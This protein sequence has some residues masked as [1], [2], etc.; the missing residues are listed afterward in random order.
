MALARTLSACLAVV[1][2]SV[3]LAATVPATRPPAK[4]AAGDAKAPSLAQAQAA[5]KVPLDWMA[6]TQVSWDV[7][8][9][10]WKDGRIEIRRLLGLGD[11]DS[12]RQAMKLTYMYMQKKDIGNGHEYPMYLYLGGEFAWAVRE[13][14]AFTGA[15]AANREKGHTEAYLN[16]ASC[17]KHF[18]E[19]AKAVQAA[20]RAIALLPDPPWDVPSEAHV[21]DVLGDIH[22]DSGDVARARA[23]WQKAMQVMPQSK[24]PYGRNLIPRK[25]AKIQAKIDLLSVAA[26]RPGSVKD[27]TYTGKSMGYVDEVTVGVTVRG[28]RITDVKVTHREN[29]PLGSTQIIPQRIVQSQSLNVQAVTAAT[30]TSDAIR[31]ACL[32]ALRQAGLR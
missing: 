26:I 6:S 14:E 15:V 27:G 30:T 28:G 31:D 18:G 24:Q 3:C 5:L 13:Y 32:Q 19:H 12:L 20:Q 7:A 8:A 21:Y 16:L 22:A 1:T 4:A 17:Y 9:K 23:A 2:A 11:Q 29:I 10:P 25:V